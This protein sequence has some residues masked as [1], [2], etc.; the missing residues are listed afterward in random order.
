MQPVLATPDELLADAFEKV[1]VARGV[2]ES[3]ERIPCVE[4]FAAVEPEGAEDL[5]GEFDRG[6]SG[7]SDDAFVGDG[8][9]VAVETASAIS[10]GSEIFAAVAGVVKVVEHSGAGEC[11]RGSADGRNGNGLNEECARDLN[12]F[13]VATRFPAVAAG[14]NEHGALIG[15]NLG[16]ADLGQDAHSAHG[17]DW[18]RG[19]SNRDDAISPR[20]ALELR[21][22]DS[23]D[24]E[25]GFPVCHR[26][27]YEKVN[28]TGVHWATSIDKTMI[29]CL[30]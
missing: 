21:I 25:C 7:S 2:A 8:G 26:V 18:S 5:T 23:S 11:Q 10:A 28:I 4:S 24:G 22:V 15:V 12:G 20:S 17:R 27:E 14:Q 19:R 13:E 30:I 6:N 29:A 3:V 1:G 16:Q 9:C